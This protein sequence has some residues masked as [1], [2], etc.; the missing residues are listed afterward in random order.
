[1]V[2][3]SL[4]TGVAVVDGPGRYRA[5][6]QHTVST[7]AGRVMAVVEVAGVLAAD[8][9]QPALTP[10]KRDRQLPH[11]PVEGD[12]GYTA[13]QVPSG[14]PSRDPRMSAA[15]TL[16]EAAETL[17]G[18]SATGATC[19]RQGVRLGVSSQG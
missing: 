12:R 18:D 19:T 7:A 5:L 3:S 17:S 11:L 4:F 2:S 1:M 16:T 15:L 6:G 8:L 9:D 10:L 13:V 14:E